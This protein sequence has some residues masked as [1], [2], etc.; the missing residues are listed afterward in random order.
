MCVC[1]GKEREREKERNAMQNLQ[2]WL[3][4]IQSIFILKGQRGKVAKEG[5]PTEGEGKHF[6]ECDRDVFVLLFQVKLCHKNY[7][8]FLASDLMEEK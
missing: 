2:V 5:R 8:V 7:F 3:D 4:S 1:E 6:L